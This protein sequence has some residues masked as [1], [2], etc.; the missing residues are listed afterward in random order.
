MQSALDAMT[1][2]PPVDGVVRPRTETEILYKTQ[3]PAFLK[4]I[5]DAGPYLTQAE[6]DAENRRSERVGGYKVF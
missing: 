1:A 5:Q 3:N 4:R 2:G 6:K